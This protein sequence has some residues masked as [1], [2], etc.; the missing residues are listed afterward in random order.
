V[1]T[2]G[3]D[4]VVEDPLVGVAGVSLASR[5]VPR[6]GVRALK[7]LVGHGLVVRSGTVGPEPDDEQP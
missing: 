3:S 6:V 4:L 1:L 7:E 2:V 5:P